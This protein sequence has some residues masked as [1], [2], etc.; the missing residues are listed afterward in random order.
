MATYKVTSPDG[1]V[2]NVT[3]PDGA[4]DAE[5]LAQVKDYKPPVADN[6]ATPAPQ[7][8]DSTSGFV[9]GNL[10]KGV[11]QLAGLPVDTVRNAA[12]LGI[13]GYG[14]VKGAFDRKFQTGGKPPDLIPPG[15]GGSEWIQ[16]KMGK[17]PGMIPPGSEP[18]SA[19]GR[20]AASAL[21]ML[22][23]AV[24]GKGTLA[25]LPAKALAGATS[26]V[27]AEVARDIGG[28][29]WAGVGAMAPGA[30]R[31]SS[32]PGVSERAAAGRK[33]DMFGKAKDLDIPIPP[34][35]MKIDKTNLKLEDVINSELKQPA[36][37]ELS[38]K[39]LA[40]YQKFHWKG[41]EDVVNAPALLNGVV[42]NPKYEQTIHDLAI[43]VEHNRQVLPRT[44]KGMAPVV[45][46]LEEYGYGQP[47]G[48][49]IPPDVTVRAIKKLRS[50][51]NTNFLS[52]D[53]EK[54]ELAK[55]QRKIAMSLE[56]L[57]E[58][59]LAASPEL[60]AKFREDRTAIAKSHDVLAALDPTTRKVSGAKL[61]QLLT[62]GKPMTGKIKDL[63]EVSGAFPESVK[64]P[65]EEGYFSH[66]VSPMAM[67]HPEAMGE[68]LCEK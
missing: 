11:A 34:R 17:V 27:G 7:A 6:P 5:V 64:V 28:D 26:G 44:F 2:Y 10:N 19:G 60:M 32:P 21:Q 35:E 42:P 33:V 45:K 22:P 25:Q 51:S 23:G 49:T 54:V 39:T 38:P 61:S 59:N 41:Y 4:T 63:A 13:A 47:Q 12:N 30:R 40:A 65:G 67:G 8:D 43:E 29:E 31:L 68:T 37:T 15:V 56:T 53:T 52:G 18:T 57:I 16:N 50:D 58:D 55:V 36:G 24:A 9:M 20:Y 46:M 1:K 14:S 3:G 66:R 62:E 48:Q